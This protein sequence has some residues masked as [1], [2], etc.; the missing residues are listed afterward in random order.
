MAKPKTE[1]KIEH[2]LIKHKIKNVF[3]N[4]IDLDEMQL[5]VSKHPF[6]TSNADA[7]RIYNEILEWETIYDLGDKN[8][9]ANSFEVKLVELKLI[10]QKSTPKNGR[11]LLK[12]KSKDLFIHS[13]GLMDL[14]VAQHPLI[15]TFADA[16]HIQ[17]MIVKRLKISDEQNKKHFNPTDFEIKLVK[18]V[19][20]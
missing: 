10:E 15:A 16:N 18:L 7:Q 14:H 3:I 5:E 20:K 6:I 11:Y 9:H 17:K 4:A 19:L 2:Y 8:Y 1:T 12:H 13:K